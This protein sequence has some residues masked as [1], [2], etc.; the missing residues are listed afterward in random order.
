MHLKKL[1]KKNLFLVSK[2]GKVPKKSIT[3][4]NFFRSIF[5]QRYVCIFEIY[6]K[7]RIF[8]YPTWPILR[9][10]IVDPYLV[11]PYLTLLEQSSA[12]RVDSRPRICFNIFL[13]FP[14]PL[15]TRYA[16]SVLIYKKSLKFDGGYCRTQNDIFTAFSY[17]PIWHQRQNY[18][19]QNIST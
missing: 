11:K 10:K 5:S 16:L 19:V 17:K 1:F 12:Q 15:P 18:N 13:S 7:I 9:K 2:N 3:L 8:S 4:N 6:I 14:G